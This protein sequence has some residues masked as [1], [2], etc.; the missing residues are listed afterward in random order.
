MPDSGDDE[1]SLVSNYVMH[2]H[3]VDLF[4]IE[5]FLRYMGS[6]FGIGTECTK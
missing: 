5:F 4:M 2:R 6:D 3:L 1:R